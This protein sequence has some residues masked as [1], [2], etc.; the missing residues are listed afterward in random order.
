MLVHIQNC[1]INEQRGL[2]YVQYFTLPTDETLIF[3]LV[4]AEAITT[5]FGVGPLVVDTPVNLLE[6]K[7]LAGVDT[8]VDNILGDCNTPD[9]LVDGGEPETN[10]DVSKI[11]YEVSQMSV[12][13]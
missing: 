3:W 1:L 11:Q 9:A 2:I 4:V 12:Q 8:V 13:V 10:W 6:C 7:L 5:E